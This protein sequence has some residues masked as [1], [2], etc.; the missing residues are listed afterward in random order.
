VTD[1]ERAYAAL[2]SKGVDYDLLWAYY[3]GNQPLR[4][5]TERLAELFGDIRTRF[6]QNWCAVVVDAAL[7]R[8][9]LMRFKV[10]DNEPAT[11]LLNALW[12][13]TEL[14]LDENDVHAAALVCGEGYVVVWPD[15]TG[16]MQAYYHDPRLAHLFYEDTNPRQKL[17]AAKWW[18]GESDDRRYLTLYYPERLEYYVSKGKAENVGGAGAFE[19]LAP[20]E[21]N[22]YGVVPVFHFRRE[23]RAIRSELGNATTPQDAINKLLADMMVAAEFGAFRQR[24]II[25]QVDPG[26]LKNS[27]N[28]IWALAASDGAGQAT[29][30]GEFSQT[31]LGVYLS[32]IDKLATSIAIIT[33]TPKHY[34]F[35]QGGVP[36]GEALI[37]ME[38]PL[39]R[40]V[41]AYIERFTAVWREVATFLLR[42]AGLDVDP[43]TIT[44]VWQPVETVQPLTESIIRQ[45]SVAAGIP[46]Y[47]QLRRE[48]WTTAELEQMAVDKSEEQQQQTATLAAAMLEQQRRMDQGQ[49]GEQVYPPGREQAQPG[50]AEQA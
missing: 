37:A 8:L 19:V 22:P 7:D 31:D 35:G 28:E 49:G 18:I 4:Y 5:S 46:L 26:R 2:A 41:Q 9:N 12:Q 32:A 33:R 48:G 43:M 36:S 3:D 10:T 40:K 45:N 14:N 11:E 39:N 13:S 50:Q 1:L 23:R 15:D 16:E 29:S 42:L 47:T 20:T 34:L 30:V 6:V 27:P 24:Y 17:F 25:S 21:K 44:P 38:A